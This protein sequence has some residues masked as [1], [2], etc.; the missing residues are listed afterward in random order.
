MQFLNR[1]TGPLLVLWGSRITLHAPRV[2][3]GRLFRGGNRAYNSM[4]TKKKETQQGADRAPGGLLWPIRRF[5][6]FLEKHLL[7]PIADSFRR[8]RN[9]FSYR[10]PFAYIGATLM[11]TVTAGA[12]AA[13][14]Y[15]Y[16]QSES[17]KTEPVT[18]DPTIAAET[19]APTYPSPT[20]TPTTVQDTTPHSGNADSTLQGVVPNF[21]TS[22]KTGSDKKSG[23]SLQK[24]PNTVVRPSPT[25]KSAPLKVAHNFATTFV[26]YE[27]GE[28]GASKAFE[29][30]ATSKLAKELKQNPPKLPSNGQIPKA[31]VVNVVSGKKSGDSMAVSVSLM[32][33][34][35]ASELRLALT[36]EKGDGWLVSEVRG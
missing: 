28:K 6:W 25:P 23:S 7:W 8:F 16:N 12:I 14:V 4:R 17:Q 31:T 36:K 30:T 15:F 24:L 18:A 5:G 13:A 27:V 1:V 32:R 20:Q 26:S 11:V 33:A 21:T 29:A 34:G 35:A 9:A 3:S 22:G 2:A 10:S 19:I